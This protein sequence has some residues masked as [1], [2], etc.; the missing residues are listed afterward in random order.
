MIV[1][2]TRQMLI[3]IWL[4][5]LVLI[6]CIILSQLSDLV[7]KRLLR[8]AHEV[9]SSFERS[10]NLNVGRPLQVGKLLLREA[11]TIDSV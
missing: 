8:T 3:Y 1:L 4:S 2:A 5:Q 7:M 10:A 6:K 9:N 11:A